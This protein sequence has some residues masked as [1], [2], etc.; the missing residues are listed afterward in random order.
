MIY[1]Y[2]TY[3]NKVQNF[4]TDS[5]NPTHM[6]RYNTWNYIFLTCEDVQVLGSVRYSTVSQI[7]DLHIGE[8]G[9]LPWPFPNYWRAFGNNREKEDKRLLKECTSRWWCV[10]CKLTPEIKTCSKLRSYTVHISISHYLICTDIPFMIISNL[11]CLLIRGNLLE[12]NP[13]I[14]IQLY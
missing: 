5:S 9:G 8:L 13:Q 7:P 12:V 2:S 10:C 3:R 6:L 11:Y 4:T 14:C 1:Y